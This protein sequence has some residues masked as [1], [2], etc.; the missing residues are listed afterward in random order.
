MK[1]IFLQLVA[2]AHWNSNSR[3]TSFFN[4][5]S[6]NKDRA[7]KEFISTIEAKRYP[8]FASQWHPEKVSFEWL[9]KNINHSADSVRANNQMSIIFVN[10]ARQNNN[11]FDNQDE[12]WKHLI[13]QFAPKYTY[14]DSFVQTYYF[15]Q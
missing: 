13:Y 15:T 4:V 2:T 3:L 8:I 11:A 7:G 10:E 14:P 12:E 6:V 5:L 9:P 1:F